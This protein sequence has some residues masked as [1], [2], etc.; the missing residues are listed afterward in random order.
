M[1]T[2]EEIDNSI[3]TKVYDDNIDIGIAYLTQYE[4][5]EDDI[6]SKIKAVADARYNGNIE[7]FV[8]DIAI[9]VE[10]KLYV[11]IQYK[12]LDLFKLQ[13]EGD[14]TTLFKDNDLTDGSV[15]DD[16]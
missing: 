2:F 1:F 9:A 7:L 3:K 8:K 13:V 6:I 12:T 15:N 5:F 10:S 4:L 14:Y 11:P 16:I